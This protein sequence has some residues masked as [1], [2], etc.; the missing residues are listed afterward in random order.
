M[1]KILL[2]HGRGGVASQELLSGIFLKHLTS[3]VLHTLED[4]A[5][6]EEHS[7]RIA[8]STDSYV[9]DPLFFP[10]G[11]IGTLAVYGTINNLAMRGAMPLALSLGVII[12]EGF[13]VVELDEIV[14]S[15]GK[16]SAEAGVAVV[17]GDTKVVARGKVDGICLNISGIGLV[18]LG[19]EISGAGAMPGDVILLSG[20]L[21]E[22]G[23]AVL[24]T[25][26]GCPNQPFVCSN[27]QPLHFLIQSVIENFPSSVHTLRDPTRGG[28][29]TSLVWI[30]SSSAVCL[31]VDE[32]SLPIKQEIRDLCRIVNHNPLYLENEGVCILICEAQHATDIL[33]LMRSLPCGKDSVIIGRVSD[34]P[35]GKVILNRGK[36]ERI[37]LQPLTEQM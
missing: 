12:E 25:R 11:N 24:T 30:A 4:S 27:I 15:I 37:F 5:L 2:D 32:K 1:D 8:F 29:A 18:P 13:L 36:G 20:C 19:E 7:G 35:A 33:G 22:H 9:G 6:L 34:G 23:L 26:N 31:E 14:R 17:T 3:P 10:G 21:A 28:L 16:A